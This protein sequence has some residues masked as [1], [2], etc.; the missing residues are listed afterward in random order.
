MTPIKINLIGEGIEIRQLVLDTETMEQWRTIA[1]KKKK[2][3]TDLIIDPF[4]YYG[5]KNSPFQS[6]EDVPAKVFSGMLDAPKTQIE[7]WFKRHKVLKFKSHDLFDEM[8]LF[9]LTQIK[10]QALFDTN[11]LPAGLYT[12]RKERGVLRSMN[13]QVAEEQIHSDDFTFHITPFQDQ[14]TLSNIMF[15]NQEFNFIKSDTLITYQS[16]FEVK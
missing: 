8:V 6:L 13:L 15:K 10:I 7:I 3:L 4:F 12:I 9:P 5:L 16:A 14:K 2:A 1:T 11:E